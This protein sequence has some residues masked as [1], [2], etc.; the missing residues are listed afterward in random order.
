M[1]VD[2]RAYLRLYDRNVHGAFHNFDMWNA[3][4]YAIRLMAL[5][6]MS[7]RLKSLKKTSNKEG[8]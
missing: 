8:R 7:Q 5:R 4:P 1:T 2:Y 3:M 6:A